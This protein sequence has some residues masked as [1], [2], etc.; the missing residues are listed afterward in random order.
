MRV[1]NVA[2]DVSVI[3]TT[4]YKNDY[5]EYNPTIILTM[6]VCNIAIDVSVIRI[7]NDYNN[8]NPINIRPN[9]KNVDENMY[10]TI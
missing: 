4:K 5:N 2:I 3:H 1:Y 9:R 10:G 6:R 8:Y 7:I